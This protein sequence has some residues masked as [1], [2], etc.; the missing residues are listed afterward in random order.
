VQP[1]AITRLVE[2]KNV[3]VQAEK[4][5]TPKTPKIESF[6]SDVYERT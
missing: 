6:E 2:A 5:K 1:D 3:L 4:L